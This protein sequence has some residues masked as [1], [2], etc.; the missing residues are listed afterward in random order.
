MVIN[1]VR[2]RYFKTREFIRGGEQWGGRMDRRLLILL[3]ALRSAWGKP[4]A[5]SNDP[6]ALGRGTGTST[7]NWLLHQTVRAADIVPEGVTTREEAHRFAYLAKA[8]GFTG[9]GCY[10]RWNQGI[11]FH[12]DTRDTDGSHIATWG[13][14]NGEYTT[15]AYAVAAIPE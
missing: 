1:G 3:D 7:H 4:I 2:L 12:V 6:G 14:I 9:V 5:I 15:L 10:P 13:R 8:L 11:G